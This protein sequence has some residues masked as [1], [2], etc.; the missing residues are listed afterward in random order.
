MSGS[1]KA[2]EN[3]QVGKEAKVDL[4][5]RGARLKA[6]HQWRPIESAPKGEMFIW[7]APRQGGKWGLGLA[8]WT[9]SGPWRDAYGAP[10]LDAT[11]WMPLP[12]PP[13]SVS[14]PATE[15]SGTHGS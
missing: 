13:A 2:G 3:S 7:A 4:P 1:I 14:E 12:E 11:H 15:G 10:S 9:V 6:S 5:L 8:Y